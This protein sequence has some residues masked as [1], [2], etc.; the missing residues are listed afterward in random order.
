VI[1]RA[2]RVAV[3]SLALTSALF[4]QAAD[5]KPTSSC[6]VCHG[7]EQRD[8]QNSVH[9]KSGIGCTGCHGGVEGPLEVE[10]AHGGSLANLR[11]PRAA[12]EACGNCHANVELMRSFGLRT[13][14]LSLYWTSKHGAKLAL[15]G[16]PKVATCVACHGA[17]GV[18]ASSDPMSS[19]SRFKQV[20]TCGRCHADRALMASYGISA[21]TIEQYASS[22]HGKAL[23]VDGRASAPA[24]TDCHGSHGALPPRFGDV[25]L[26]C[27]NCHTTIQG[28]FDQS[29]H[30]SHDRSQAKVECIS[31]HSN[32][33]V[34]KPSSA[35]FLGDD[36][37]HCG[38]CHAADTD[39]ALAVAR[40]LQG[41]LQKLAS[42]IDGAEQEVRAAGDR[43]LFLG[44]E[45]GYVDEARGLFVRARAMTHTL[46]P[47]ALDDVLNRGQAMVGQTMESL[48]TKER[49][50]RDRK[51]FTGLFCG[52]SLVFAVVLWMYGRV[53]RGESR[54]RRGA[55]AL[56][57]AR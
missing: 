36:A 57:G 31:C 45:R 17:H 44:A 6:G 29:P 34:Q 43:G 11:D 37:G 33:A 41:D 23:L 2:I 10:A 42:T 26:V 22:V 5:A 48:A 16:D 1:A 46:S 4:A 13:D 21:D 56:G 19:V 51:I 53:I 55:R 38:S 35:M 28:F 8:L 40:T 20:E 32:H 24:C 49:V 47:A 7:K 14:Q 3:A 25:E 15:D 52:I 9:A 30:A 12:V 54:R 18:L 27:G 39:P 50:F